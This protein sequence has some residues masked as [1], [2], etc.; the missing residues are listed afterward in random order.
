MGFCGVGFEDGVG[1]EG[2]GNGGLVEG[3]MGGLWSKE[4]WRGS[5]L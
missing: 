5:G 4:R 1:R 3:G 2:G